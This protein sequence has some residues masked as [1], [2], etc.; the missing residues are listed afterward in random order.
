L[1]QLFNREPIEISNRLSDGGVR[2]S[3]QRS[4]DQSADDASPIHVATPL[5]SSQRRSPHSGVFDW[6]A[7]AFI[8]E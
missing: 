2:D 4:Q 6:Q 3:K 5:G 7:R 8:V 1:R